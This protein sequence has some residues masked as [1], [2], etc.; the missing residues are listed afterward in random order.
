LSPIRSVP[1]ASITVTAGAF[2]T[3]IDYRATLSNMQVQSG[4]GIDV[5]MVGGQAQVAVASNVALVDQPSTWMN[6]VNM[7]DA[8]KTLPWRT[9]IGSPNGA[10][11][12]RTRVCPCGRS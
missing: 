4:P 2:D 12:A 1:I 9:G 10:I 5:T 6:S 11:I 3:V 8:T 7:K